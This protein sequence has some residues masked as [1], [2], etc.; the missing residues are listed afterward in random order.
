MK[1]TVLVGFLIAVVIS[2]APVQAAV[3]PLDSIGSFLKRGGDD[4]GNPNV[5]LIID[6]TVFGFSAGDNLFLEE[7]GDF[8]LGPDINQ[9]DDV[10]DL[11]IG[12]F[13]STNILLGAFQR[14]R[15]PDAIDA[16][17]DRFTGKTFTT[18]EDT[19]IAEDFAIFNELSGGTNIVIP[20]GA[21]FLFVGT[22]DSLSRDNSDPDGDYAL[23]ISQASA[24]IP[25]PAALPLFL[26][27]LAGLGLLRRRQR[28]A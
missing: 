4:G 25:L 14:F 15:V 22:A 5:L 11:T 6:L 16:G 9:I 12:V 10:V 2:V 18:Q 27:G 3:I 26:T 1:I 19:D 21:L 17:V 7:L 28:Q 13:S 20:T 24:V 8:D 23:R